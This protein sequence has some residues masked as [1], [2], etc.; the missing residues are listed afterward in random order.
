MYSTIKK[1]IYILL[2]PAEGGAFWDKLIDSFIISLILL[3]VVAVILETV[4]SISLAYGPLFKN[5]E[6]FS[7]YFFTIE[8]A[9]RV[10]T[11][12]YIA[13]YKHPVTGRL[14]YIFSFGSLI[15][16]LAIVPFYLPFSA[17]YDFR[18]IRILRLIRFL[19]VFKIGRYLNATKII[20]NVFKTKKEELVLCLL[21]TLTLIVIASSL[22]YFVEHDAQPDKFSSIPESMW[23]SVT[24]LTTVGYGDVYPVTGLGRILTACISILGIGIF[25]LPAGILASGFSA[26]FQ[27]LKKGK[28]TCPH[29]GNELN[30]NQ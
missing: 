26:E 8:Y 17:F 10:W 28:N 25:A 5:F 3:N 14:R 29:C 20:S 16:L 19:R 12:T 4:D 18:F 1:H 2:D 30:N 27:K 9:L 21:I 22:M 13:K 7:V 24:T 15:D 23:W 6:I 11:C